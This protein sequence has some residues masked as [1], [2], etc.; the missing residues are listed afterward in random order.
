[1]A[2]PDNNQWYCAP[3]DEQ[4]EEEEELF[5]TPK[6]STPSKNPG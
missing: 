6:G 4:R 5:S 1:M 3:I 2:K